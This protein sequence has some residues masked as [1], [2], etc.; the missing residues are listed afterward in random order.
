M[1]SV[2]SANGALTLTLTLTLALTLALAR[3]L[4]LTL[5]LN[6]TPEMG[7]TGGNS[8]EQPMAMAGRPVGLPA[9]SAAPS[10][11]LGVPSCPETPGARA[12]RRHDCR[13]RALA[14]PMGH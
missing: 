14:A 3:T 1:P 4:T 8:P 12:L 2:G 9:P 7:G 11:P 13:C 6:H 10:L 5:T